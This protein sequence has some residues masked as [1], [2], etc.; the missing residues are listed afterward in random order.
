MRARRIAAALAFAIGAG[1]TPATAADNAERYETSW[2][3]VPQDANESTRWVEPGGVVTSARLIPRKLYIL[4]DG[5]TT[6]GATILP[7]GTELVAPAAADTI[8]CT[9]RSRREGGAQQ[10]QR[11]FICLIDSDHDGRFDRYFDGR[12]ASPDFFIGFGKKPKTMTAIQPARFEAR[13]AAL[14]SDSPRVYLQYFYFASVAN[15]LEFQTCLVEKPRGS[16]GC[17]GNGW[18][19]VNR[20]KLPYDFEAL[21]GRFRVEAKEE[22][23]VRVTMLSPFAAQ[24]FIVY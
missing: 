7:P 5:V 15:E 22:S 16:V 17:F 9:I 1:I 10:F 11:G 14:V 18:I 2:A 12:S 8:G 4:P 6:G 23:R 13:E 19:R 24:P 3:V 21:G 20:A